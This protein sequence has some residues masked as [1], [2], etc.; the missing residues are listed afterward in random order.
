M[1]PHHHCS[2]VM[3][4]DEHDDAYYHS[5]FHA[6]PHIGMITI[7]CGYYIYNS[8]ASVVLPCIWFV[9]HMWDKTL[10]VVWFM[11]LESSW[12]F[13]GWNKKVAFWILN[14]TYGYIIHI[15][16]IYRDMYIHQDIRYRIIHPFSCCEKLPPRSRPCNL[17]ARR[18]C[19]INATW[20]PW[21]LGVNGSPRNEN[22]PEPK[23]KGSR[24]VF[25]G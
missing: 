17:C 20:Q 18:V 12:T 23:K 5:C 16:I 24:I 22:R 8:C 14:I 7:T 6:F 10:L 3:T 15:Y 1:Q 11:T 13:M 9:E 25:I 4:H 21:K 2:L 19:P